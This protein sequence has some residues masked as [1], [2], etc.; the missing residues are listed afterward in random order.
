MV[1]YSI[2][3]ISPHLVGELKTALKSIDSYGSV[4]IFV[5]DSLVTQITVRNIK[6]TNQ[7][8]HHK[9]SPIKQT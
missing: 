7:F 2:K 5:Q 8:H 9:P 4:E 3:K 1:N 6:K